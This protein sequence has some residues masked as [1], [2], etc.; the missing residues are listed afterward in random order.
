MGGACV[1]CAPKDDK[2]QKEAELVDQRRLTPQQEQANALAAA[3]RSAIFEENEH[4]SQSEMEPAKDESG[5]S[6]WELGGGKEIEEALEHTPLVDLEYIVLLARNGGVMPRQQEVPPAAFVTRRN[7]WRVRQWQARH[8]K[9]SLGVLVLSYPWLDWFHPDREGAQLRRLLPVFEA[10]L[11]E[12][13][14]DSPHCTVG[15]MIDFMCVLQKPYGS[16]E[17]KQMQKRSLDAINLWYFHALTHVLLVTTPPPLGA[18]YG[19]TR[20]HAVRG[21]CYFEKMAS[22]VA[23]KPWL[24]LDFSKYVDATDFGRLLGQNQGD[25]RVFDGVAPDSCCGQMS[26]GR[27][28]PQS[29]DCFGESMRARVRAGELSF[30]SAAD[31]EHVIEQYRKGFVETLQKLA[32][33]ESTQHRIFGFDGLGWSNADVDELLQV[34][35]AAVKLCCFPHGPIG[36]VMQD[37]PLVTEE[38]FAELRR[39]LAGKFNVITD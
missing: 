22:M 5:R 28:A 30:T 26:A 10:M 18:V 9:L 35:L 15:V 25:A 17:E 13:K 39:S 33:C 19:N 36:L 27:N 6:R 1:R 20:L 32:D 16:P 4:R 21:W 14:C 11:A 12:A 29:P 8:L 7:L 37:N 34:L 23:T 2:A 31:E 24:L 38:K 3:R